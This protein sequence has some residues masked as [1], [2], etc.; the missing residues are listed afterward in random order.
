MTKELV[1][2][3]LDG[4]LVDSAQVVSSILNQLRQEIGKDKKPTAYF[5]P[6]LSLGG[7]ELMANGLGIEPSRAEA[8]LTEFRNRYAE[9][10]TPIDTVY[11]GVFDALDDLSAQNIK[12]CVCTNKPRNL[13]QKVLDETGLDRYFEYL[14]AGGDLPSKKPHPKNLSICIEYFGMQSEQVALVGDS[15]IDQKMAAS[16]GVDF[17]FFTRGY[18]DCVDRSLIN[19]SF[20]NHSDLKFIIGKKR[21]SNEYT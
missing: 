8:F 11:E 20:K 21:R 16:L 12:M 17:Y 18:D 15:T 7:M 6:W 14:C 4:T 9:I 1:V 5:T 10:S 3:D 13:A 19:F 2:F